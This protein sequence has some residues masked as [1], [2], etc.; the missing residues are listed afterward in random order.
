[1]KEIELPKLYAITDREKYGE[2]F[3][4]TLEGVLERGVRFVQLREKELPD[5]EL[6]RLAK[7]V[8]ELTR[9]Y[10]A[11]LT[12]NSRFDV[13]L[14]VGAEGV[15]LPQNSLPPSAV[16]SKYPNLLVGFSAHDLESALYAQE[17]GADYI[18]LSPIFKTSSHPSA[19]PLGIRKLEEISKKV[20]IPIY[21]LGGINWNRTKTC[22]K[23]G[24][25]GIAGIT[26]FIT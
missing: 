16:K 24:A 13:A 19:K 21:A 15:H 20:Q 25:Y 4:E 14:A 7:K 26:I 23:A 12:I 22:Y 2:N 1:M 8:R 9:R 17:E 11:L 10:G 6:Y 18:T 3:M 5:R